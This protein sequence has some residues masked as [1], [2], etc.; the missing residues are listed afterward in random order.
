[1]VNLNKEICNK[2]NM[3]IK[4]GTL[5]TQDS[6]KLSRSAAEKNKLYAF[7]DDL[8]TEINKYQTWLNRE[9][10]LTAECLLSDLIFSITA[11]HNISDLLKEIQVIRSKNYVARIGQG[12]LVP[13]YHEL[14]N[15]LTKIK[16]EQKILT[17]NIQI[18][19]AAGLSALGL[20]EEISEAEA[21][22]FF[23]Q[24]EE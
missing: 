7:V 13:V 2:K 6:G 9:Q 3:I 17:E 11:T 14:N 21:D 23:E 5:A 4:N 12:I 18:Y 1:M 15:Q 16:N 19:V 22:K 8:K 10:I 20:D 24:D